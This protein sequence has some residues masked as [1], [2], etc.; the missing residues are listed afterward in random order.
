MELNVS[1]GLS[2][3]SVS[4]VCAAFHH[5]RERSRPSHW[6][7]SFAGFTGYG[8]TASGENHLCSN[9]CE[10]LTGGASWVTS[11]YLICNWNCN[12]AVDTFLTLHHRFLSHTHLS[13][14][15]HASVSASLVWGRQR[16]QEKKWQNSF[17]FTTHDWKQ[18]ASTS[19]PGKI[20]SY[21]S[22][23]LI[24]ANSGAARRLEGVLEGWGQL[25]VKTVLQSVCWRW[26]KTFHTS[27]VCLLLSLSLSLTC[28]LHA[29]LH[30]TQDLPSL[31]STAVCFR[32]N[33]YGSTYMCVRVCVCV[34]LRAAL[35]PRTSEA[36]IN[37]H[38]GD[39]MLWL[40]VFYKRKPEPVRLA[41][42]HLVCVDFWSKQL[43]QSP[44]AQCLLWDVNV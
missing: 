22:Y 14:T 30:N 33:W 10:P 29:H 5:H 3:E 12:W 9:W 23:K 6:N 21:I 15:P 42:F 24:V 4:H 34:C 32:S 31:Y 20:N 2:G 41:W 26:S 27:S 1:S 25:E 36:F 28:P 13:P 7:K 17:N 35:R 40:A 38:I 39:Q 19:Q 43:P 11:H 37:A 8:V 44:Q 18:R 16:R